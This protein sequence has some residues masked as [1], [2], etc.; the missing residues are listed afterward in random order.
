M[1]TSPLVIPNRSPYQPYSIS[2]L[3]YQVPCGNCLECRSSVQNEWY[4]RLCYDIDMFYRNGG[5]G[6]FLTFTYRDEDL[7]QFS[8]LGISAFNHDHILDFLD[9]INSRVQKKYGKF[10]YH[11]F[12]CSEYGKNTNRPHY[13]GL[14]LLKSLVDWKWFV[15]LCREKWTYGFMFPK[16]D[17]RKQMYLDD[18]GKGNE[19]ILRAGIESAKYVSKYITKDMTFYNLDCVRDWLDKSSAADFT[20]KFGNVLTYGKR[21]ELIKK[22]LPKHWQSKGIGLSQLDF[23]DLSSL[24]S[25]TS[26]LNNGV[27]CPLTCTY[28]PISQYCINKLLYKSV[29]SDRVSLVTNRPIY[30]RVLTSFGRENMKYVYKQRFEKLKQK[31]SEFVQSKH[32]VD[33]M[34]YMDLKVDFDVLA[35][36]KLVYRF[37]DRN[38][39]MYG[40]GLNDTNIGDV[41]IAS[42]IFV[43]NKDLLARKAFVKEDSS[44]YISDMEEFLIRSYFDNLESYLR[45]F[46][47]VSFA[48]RQNMHVKKQLE[49][50]EAK[51]LKD[52]YFKRYNTNLM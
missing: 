11:Y 38:E 17:H 35:N 4:V 34:P 24:D 21:K 9:K 3:K 41:D 5:I 44:F 20:D 40:Y 27:W 13:H 14:F 10:M 50:D 15:E 2:P 32:S 19:P 28:L 30:E 8:P 39:L 12:I 37:M 6:V 25:V 43:L 29:R 47:F 23:V 46:E 22:Y 16:F 51:A 36:Y 48:D 49:Y 7:P 45:A 42:D 31:F 33:D 1:C 52:K 26:A 18:D